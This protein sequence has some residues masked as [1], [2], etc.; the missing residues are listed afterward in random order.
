MGVLEKAKQISEQVLAT[1]A[2]KARLNPDAGATSGEYQGP[3]ENQNI[4]LRGNEINEESPPEQHPDFDSVDELV[5]YANQVWAQ[6][7][8]A[9]QPVAVA[10]RLHRPSAEVTGRRRTFVTLPGG[11]VEEVDGLVIPPDA[12]AWCHEGDKAWTVC[13]AKV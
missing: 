7:Y 2:S 10:E 3:L 4:P 6:R 12:V 1:V 9:R 5:R 13:N 8:P 11:R